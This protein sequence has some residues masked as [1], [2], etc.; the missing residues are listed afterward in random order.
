MDFDGNNDYASV[1]GAGISDYSEA[2][3]MGIW[4]RIDSTATWDNGY[5]SNI[6]SIAGSYAGQYG[7]FK[8]DSDEFGVQLR[9]ADSTIYATVSGNSKGVWYNLVSKNFQQMKYFKIIMVP[10]IYPVGLKL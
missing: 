7:L 10:P 1:N 3:S 2:F 6:Y 8:S 5:R 4:F 9:D